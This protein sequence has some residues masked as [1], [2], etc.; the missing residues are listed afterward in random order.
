MLHCT[1]TE[2]GGPGNETRLRLLPD[3]YIDRFQLISCNQISY[4]VCRISPEWREAMLAAGFIT[5]FAT[6]RGGSGPA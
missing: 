3:A 2:I 6:T 5:E 1:K 4:L